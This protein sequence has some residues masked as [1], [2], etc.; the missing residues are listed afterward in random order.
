MLA[1][2]PTL[3]AAEEI[4]PPEFDKKTAAKESR[5]AVD[6]FIKEWNT[7]DNGKLR[8]ALHFPFVTVARNGEMDVAKTPDEFEIDF[9][10]MRARQ[11]WDHSTFD[12]IEPILIAPEK[13]HYKVIW[14]RHNSDGKRYV[15]GEIVYIA[16][17]K[18]GRWAIV[19]RSPIW[20]R[21]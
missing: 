14:S 2:P 7:G 16:A 3:P 4:S 8:K 17:K 19:L 15:T 1:I 13:A 11:N 21:K 12:K 6:R 10:R 20:Y 18:E 5:A 9:A